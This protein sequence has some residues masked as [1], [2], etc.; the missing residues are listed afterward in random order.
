[1]K[2]IETIAG[3]LANIIRHKQTEEA[4]KASEL[5]FRTF[6]DHSSLGVRIRNTVDGITYANQ[7]FLDIFGY[8]NVEE[9]R[10]HPPQEFYAQAEYA[11]YLQRK[12]KIERGETVARKLEVDI[13]RKDGSVRHVQ[14]FAHVVHRDGWTQANTFYNDITDLKN[15]KQEIAEQQVLTDRIMESTSNPVVVI[16]QDKRIIMVNKAFQHMFEMT[17]T[18]SE[19]RD[20]AEIIPVPRLLEKISQV[21]SSGNRTSRQSLKSNAG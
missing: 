16:G 7:A 21:L 13:V 15:S 12:Q 2:R 14:I 1:M 10:L 4:L 3:Q 6:L 18:K 20:I 8:Q 9:S 17:R 11:D 19:G 5:N